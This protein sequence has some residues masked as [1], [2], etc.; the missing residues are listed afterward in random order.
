MVAVMGLT[1][2][3]ALRTVILLSTRP[4]RAALYISLWAEL[5][6]GPSPVTS[7]LRTVRM[8]GRKSVVLRAL[9][10]ADTVSCSSV[11]AI[12]PWVS[13]TA[14]NTSRAQLQGDRGSHTHTPRVS[15]TQLQGDTHTHHEFVQIL[16][17]L[18]FNPL[19]KV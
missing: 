15:R 2:A 4:L 9:V 6:E 11:P 16:H 12:R 3:A 19:D 1:L 13:Y 7:L 5:E 18:H 17:C 14:P 8:S 10:S